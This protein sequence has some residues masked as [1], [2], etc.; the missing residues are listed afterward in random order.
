M[1]PVD[2]PE[3]QLHRELRAPW[4]SRRSRVLALNRRMGAEL[5]RQLPT[6]TSANRSGTEHADEN[7]L[8]IFVLLHAL[9]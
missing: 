1:S 9:Q 7:F 4:S 6:T 8:N 3:H 2:C 5:G